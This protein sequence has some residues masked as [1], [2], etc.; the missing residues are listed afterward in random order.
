MVDV[1]NIIDS[2]LKEITL[3]DTPQEEENVLGD[4]W[5]DVAY[6]TINRAIATGKT[7][8][9]RCI[10]GCRD[11]RCKQDCDLRSTTLVLRTLQGGITRCRGDKR[12]VK[13]IASRIINVAERGDQKV[14]KY[15]FGTPYL[16]AAL[17]FVT[18]LGF[19]ARQ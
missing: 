6:D 18:R 4:A 12:C 3:V 2:Y 15:G 7:N 11:E 17:A 19:Q 16:R 5:R 13:A 8:K 1:N 14:R 10:N 9:A